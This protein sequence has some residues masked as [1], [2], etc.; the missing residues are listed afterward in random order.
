MNFDTTQS[1]ELVLKLKNKL[2]KFPEADCI[3]CPPFTSIAFVSELLS[4]S[5][6]R[7]GAQNMHHETSGAYTGEISGLMLKDYCSYVILGHSERRAHFGETSSFINKKVL[8]ALKL[9]ISPIL[10]IGE[11]LEQREG[12]RAVSVC[13]DQ[14]MQGLSDVSPNHLSK[15]VI[16]YEPVWAIGTGMSASP[17]IAQEIMG[18]LRMKFS[19]LVSDNIYETPFLYGGSVNA[20]NAA[21]FSKEKDINGALVGGASLNADSFINITKSMVSGK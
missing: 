8:A 7:V 6:I 12:D 2:T 9:G 11:T 10:C 3:I 18:T 13:L 5:S 15:V 21:D 16:A 4:G 1:R 14:M 19:E 17:N 20:D